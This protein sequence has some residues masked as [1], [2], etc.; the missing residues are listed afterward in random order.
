MWNNLTSRLWLFVSV[1]VTMTLSDP[2]PKTVLYLSWTDYQTIPQAILYL[3]VAHTSRWRH[4]VQCSL[5]CVS[6]YENKKRSFGK[7]KRGKSFCQGL[8]FTGFLPRPPEERTGATG[9]NYRHGTPDLVSPGKCV[10]SGTRAISLLPS[11]HLIRIS[12]LP[13]TIYSNHWV[14]VGHDATPHGCVAT[15]AVTNLWQLIISF[16]LVT[17]VGG[18]R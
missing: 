10:L 16:S 7:K 9:G 14:R 12:A 4:P 13:I 2:I 15:L 8:V 11:A 1:C 5:A 6:N 3:T 18:F 17:A